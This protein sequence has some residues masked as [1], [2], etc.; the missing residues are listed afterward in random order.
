MRLLLVDKKI[1]K[2]K[3]EKKIENNRRDDLKR[4][5]I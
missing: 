3:N 2:K 5:T 1:Q 4:I